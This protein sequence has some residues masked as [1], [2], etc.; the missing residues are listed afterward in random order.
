MNMTSTMNMKCITFMQVLLYDST[1]MAVHEGN[2]VYTFGEIDYL[3]YLV[4]D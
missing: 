4:Q 1:N 2:I 3:L